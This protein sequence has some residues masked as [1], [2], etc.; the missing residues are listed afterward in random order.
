MVYHG[1]WSWQFVQVKGSTG[2]F[3]ETAKVKGSTGLS[4][5]TAKV[6][7]STGLSEETAQ[8]KGSTSLSEERAGWVVNAKEYTFQSL[9]MRLV[10]CQSKRGQWS[11]IQ[12]KNGFIP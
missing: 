3:E 11:V 9:Q 10:V 12:S 5:E 6:K 4:E 2:L 1:K 8:V 7:G